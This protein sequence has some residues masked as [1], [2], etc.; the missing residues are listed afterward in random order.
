MGGGGG[1]G[2]YPCHEL[3]SWHLQGVE[4]LIYLTSW[5]MLKEYVYI[6]S[7]NMLLIIIPVIKLQDLIV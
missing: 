2:G 4:I 7:N 6:I 1:G 5:N 3:S